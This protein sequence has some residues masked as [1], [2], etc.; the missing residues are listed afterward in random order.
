[1]NRPARID[2]DPSQPSP[3]FT[4]AEFLRM[5]DAGAFADMRV[6]LVEGEIVKMMPA[7]LAHGEAN[8][9]LAARL[10]AAVGQAG[11]IGTDVLIA[12][13]DKTMRAADIV[14]AAVG[15]PRDKALSPNE[16]TLVVEIADSTLAEDLGAKLADYA[17]IGI[18]H[19]WVVDLKGRIIQCMTA[20]RNGGYEDRVVVRFGE[21]LTLPDGRRIVGL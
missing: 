14:V 13:S 1:M 3:W 7:Y 9:T 12:I 10:L 16:V 4:A 17:A 5:R 21:E 18:A 8:L 11:V 19:Y 2:T 20:P 6:E 15:A